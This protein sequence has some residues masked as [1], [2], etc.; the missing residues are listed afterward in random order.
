MLAEWTAERRRNLAWLATVGVEQRTHGDVHP[1]HGRI[2][3]EEH[4]VEWAYHDL[5]HLRQMLGALAGDLYPHL[6][7]WQGLYERPLS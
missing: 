7:A 1:R 6:G 2:T 3:L 5:D 4:V